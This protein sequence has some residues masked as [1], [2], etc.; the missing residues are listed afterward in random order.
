MGRGFPRPGAV[1][2]PI[3]RRAGVPRMYH[4]ATWNLRA[5]VADT[6]HQPRG[7]G[8]AIPR[9]AS[10]PRAVRFP[11]LPPTGVS[12]TPARSRMSERGFS[13]V[14][15]PLWL[16][17]ATA[18]A[19]QERFRN[20]RGP[21]RLLPVTANR[22]HRHAISRGTAIHARPPASRDGPRWVTPPMAVSRPDAI[23]DAF[24]Q[25]RSPTA[26]NSMV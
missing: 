16:V 9:S 19:L 18:L 4:R 12:R 8:S 17:S 23:S 15:S 10:R 3:G 21:P 25:A 14:K 11:R 13:T 24:N 1:D 2:S 5:G 20:G 22:H 6:G 26:I 7:R